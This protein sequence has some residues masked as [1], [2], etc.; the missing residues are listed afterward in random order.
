MILVEL[1]ERIVTTPTMKTHVMLGNHTL[2]I[3]SEGQ[4]RGEA[5]HYYTTY[6]AFWGCSLQLCCILRE[7]VFDRCDIF[8][9]VYG[10]IE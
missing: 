6:V 3:M 4:G 9:S 10:G 5:V 8:F 7:H 2:H 1:V